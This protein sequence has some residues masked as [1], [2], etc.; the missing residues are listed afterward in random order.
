VKETIHSDL[1]SSS[2]PRPPT[3]HVSSHQTQ[4]LSLLHDFIQSSESSCSKSQSLLKATYRAL[5][6]LALAKDAETPLK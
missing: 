2:E 6:R 4:N 1:R 5:A 3:Q